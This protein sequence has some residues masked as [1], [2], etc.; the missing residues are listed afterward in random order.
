VRVR[1]VRPLDAA[2][3]LPVILPIALSMILGRY[4]CRMAVWLQEIRPP[5]R[6]SFLPP[7][8][9]LRQASHHHRPPKGRGVLEA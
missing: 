3:T 9:R 6:R 4:M 8:S 7:R 2:G 5:L 1:I